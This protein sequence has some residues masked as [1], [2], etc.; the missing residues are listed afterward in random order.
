MA[1][2]SD[3]SPLASSPIWRFT[4]KQLFLW[5]AFIALGCVALRNASATWVSTMFGLTLLLLGASLLLALFRDGQTRAYWIGFATLGWLY[6]FVLLYGWNLDSN[7][8]TFGNNPLRPSELATTRLTHKAYEW[9]YPLVPMVISQPG[10]GMM[11]GPA[12]MGMPMGAMMGT[13][14]GSP[15][16]GAGESMG[17]SGMMP[18]GPAGSGPMMPGGGGPGMPGMMGAGTVTAMVPSPGPSQQDF[19]N[20][21]HALWTL[22]LAACGGWLATWLYATRPESKTEAADDTT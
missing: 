2:D 16:G 11:G 18:G 13:G 7:T 4:L 8:A 1:Q 3:W 20:V 21:A 12:G 14:A 19:T 5:T 15:E 9:L 10:A 17:A 6:V 22:V